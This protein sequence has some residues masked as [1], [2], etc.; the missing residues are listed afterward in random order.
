L[1]NRLDA[2]GNPICPV[3][4]LL[5]VKPYASPFVGEQ[6]VH[7]ECWVSPFSAQRQWG[8]AETKPDAGTMRLIHMDHRTKI[9]RV[10]CPCGGQTI[11][12]TVGASEQAPRM[13]W[14]PNCARTLHY[15]N[16]LET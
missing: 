10:E 6:Q 3:C 1:K 15:P 11:I 14:C 9:A 16:D 13:G 7:Q 4:E 8:T 2:Q 12:P 5:I